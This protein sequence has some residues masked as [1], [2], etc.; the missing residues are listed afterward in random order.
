[1]LKLKKIP[2]HKNK[3]AFN[4]SSKLY[5][6]S[7]QISNPIYA[8]NSGHQTPTATGSPIYYLFELVNEATKA[9]YDT[10]LELDK[11]STNARYIESY[12]YFG[13]ATRNGVI[14]LPQGGKYIYNI[15][16]ILENVQYPAD[17][18]GEANKNARIKIESGVAMVYDDYEFKAK[19]YDV[20][21]KAIPAVK[22]YKNE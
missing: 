4:Y 14:N 21:N 12:V 9:K 7:R 15:Y 17:T 3:I 2:N 8:P 16:A 5:S 13:T 11:Q 22:V 10:V 1:M 18:M 6:N 19:Y 20:D